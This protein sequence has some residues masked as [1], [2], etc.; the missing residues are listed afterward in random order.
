MAGSHYDPES[1]RS[2]LRFS[3]DRHLLVEGS[4][5]KRVFTLFLDELHQVHSGIQ[6]NVIVDSAEHLIDFGNIITNREKV[7]AIC[8]S[9][10]DLPYAG[11]LVGFVDRDFREFDRAPLLQ[12]RIGAHKVS[13]R[14]VWSRGHSI[15][16]Y[17]FE[18]DILRSSL[19]TFSVTDKFCNALSLFEAVF[20][21]AIRLACAA[22]LAGEELQQLKLVKASVRQEIFQLRNDTNVTVALDPA[23]WKENLTRYHR[24]SL[25]IAEKLTE[26]F[27]FWSERVDE[28]DFCAVRWMCHG[29]IGL[30]FIW[31]VYS[32][33]VLES[34]QQKGYS[35][36]EAAAEAQRV[37]KAEESVRFNACAELWVRKA[38]GDHCSYPAEVFRLLDISIPVS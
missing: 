11:R 1:Y 19:R 35:K 4:D 29:H 25:D 16:N 3:H 22:S 23:K 37:L 10:S 7:E 38:L 28:S 6:F 13:G 17:Y 33:C 27:Q 18:F 2:Y 14:L 32:R 8:L 15:E 9:V 21:Q 34:C 36:Q 31:A 24:V 30:A 5:D 26:R 12:D 20:E